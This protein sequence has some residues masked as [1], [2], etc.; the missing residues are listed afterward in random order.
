V[1]II[2]SWKSGIQNIKALTRTF[3]SI[4]WDGGER[5]CEIF[6]RERI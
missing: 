3:P 1:A 6:W 2:K 4:L 5:I